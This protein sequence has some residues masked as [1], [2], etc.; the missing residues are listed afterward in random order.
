MDDIDFITRHIDGLV[1]AVAFGIFAVYGLWLPWKDSGPFLKA[2]VKFA[3][4][5]QCVLLAAI[6]YGLTGVGG[7][8][9][10]ALNTGRNWLF[11]AVLTSGGWALGTLGGIAVAVFCF[12]IW[13][14]Y[15]APGGSEPDPNKP[16][17]HLVIW[18]DSL[19]LHPMLEFLTGSTAISLW[20]IVLGYFAMWFINVKFRGGKKRTPERATAAAATR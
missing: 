3:P 6:G 1:L 9:A 10:G 17:A 20:T 19:L 13:F 5:V 15:L 8:V 7:V 16:I 11:D 12:F 18:A 4:K 14:D 2:T